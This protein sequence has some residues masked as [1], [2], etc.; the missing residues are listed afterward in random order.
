MSFLKEL[1]K[2]ED[3]KRAKEI[4]AE[5]LQGANPNRNFVLST[6]KAG[7]G[8]WKRETWNITM[9]VGCGGIHVAQGMSKEYC[10]L[11]SFALMNMLGFVEAREQNLTL[12]PK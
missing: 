2:I 12:P 9:L 11:F 3:V 1:P 5:A 7:W 4:F 8:P 10:R 6:T